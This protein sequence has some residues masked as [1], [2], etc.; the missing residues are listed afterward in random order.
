[1][2]S[3]V[4]LEG[5][6]KKIRVN[7]H[8]RYCMARLTLEIKDPN[9]PRYSNNPIARKDIWVEKDKQYFHNFNSKR[10]DKRYYQLK[11]SVDNDLDVYAY[12]MPDKTLQVWIYNQVD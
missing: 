8:G 4:I 1:M 11:M 3:T 10:F 2:P 5:D 6:F 9:H 7:N 12:C